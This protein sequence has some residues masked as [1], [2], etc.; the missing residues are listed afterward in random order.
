MNE[1]AEICD[2]VGRAFYVDGGSADI[3]GIISNIKADTD[4][5]Q[6]TAGIAVHGRGNSDITL[7]SDCQIKDINANASQGSL[8]GMYASDLDMQDDPSLKISMGSVL[9]I[10]MI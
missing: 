5:W 3:D 4:M 9:Y 1:G 2:V 7:K 10:W 6:G 8:L